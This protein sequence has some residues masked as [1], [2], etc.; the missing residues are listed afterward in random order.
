MP[1]ISHADVIALES[2][3]DE[4]HEKLPV[5]RRF[6][7]PG[8][9]VVAAQLHVARSV[10]RKSERRTVALA[11]EETVNPEVI[12]YLNRLSSLLFELARFVNRVGRVKEEEWIH[13]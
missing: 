7:L 12:I 4:V 10:C 5:L 6:I 11:R 3:V 1:R 9:T 13:D 8:G 2:I